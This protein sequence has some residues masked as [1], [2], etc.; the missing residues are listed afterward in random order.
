MR[1][2]AIGVSLRRSRA[3]YE[4][5]LRRVG[6]PAS[7]DTFLLSIKAAP[8]CEF[9]LAFAS[10]IPAAQYADV[11]RW[12]LQKMG[13]TAPNKKIDYNF[14]DDVAQFDETRDV[15]L[16]LRLFVEGFLYCQS[17]GV[18]PTARTIKS[19]R[20]GFIDLTSVPDVT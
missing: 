14:P 1:K 2:K 19:L 6:R 5:G 16:S 17:Q 18:A 7:P 4:P 8:G 3:R 13:V 11:V 9:S 15:G 10:Y 12:Y 20:G